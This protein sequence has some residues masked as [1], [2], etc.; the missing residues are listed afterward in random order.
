MSAF[1]AYDVRGVFN[2]DFDEGVAYK[3]GYFFVY[4]CFKYIN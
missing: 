2:V 1:H 3:I 4:F